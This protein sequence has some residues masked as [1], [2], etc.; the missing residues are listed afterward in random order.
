MS[1]PP[2]LR[3]YANALLTPV[4]QPTTT[5]L[6]VR[7]TKRGTTAINYA[8]DGYDDDDFEDTESS[9]NRPTGLRSIRSHDSNA[10]KAGQS[11]QAGVTLTEPVQ[12]QG[13]WREWMGKTHNM[14]L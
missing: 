13:I 14:V 2:R 4:T 1:Y 9:R 3:T 11:N 7:T 8:E 6:P 10:D 12:M 5:A